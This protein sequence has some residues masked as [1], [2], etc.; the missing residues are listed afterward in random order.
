MLRCGAVYQSEIR[1][2]D[3]GRG[4][5][6]LPRLFMRKS[7]SS[8]SPQLIIDQRQQLLAGTGVALLD[9]RQDES[10]SSS[11]FSKLR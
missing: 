4:L 2:M 8:Q 3:Q 11:K 9:G 1:F 6:S 10:D 5:K 7:L